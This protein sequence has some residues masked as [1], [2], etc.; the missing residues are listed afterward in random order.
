MSYSKAKMHQ[1]RLCLGL[2]ALP[3][4]PTGF[5]GPTSKGRGWGSLLHESRGTDAP[6]CTFL[7]LSSRK[8]VTSSLVS[9][10][11]CDVVSG[12]DLFTQFVVVSCHC[13]SFYYICCPCGE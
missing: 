12:A 8:L 9:A 7:L 13:A 5:K 11:D 6:V 1:I 3:Q 10:Y 4:T 2:T